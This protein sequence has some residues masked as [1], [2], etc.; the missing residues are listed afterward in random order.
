MA[1]LVSQWLIDIPPIESETRLLMMK[2]VQCPF[3]PN[4]VPR[5]IYQLHVEECHCETYRP[6]LLN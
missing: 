5:T 1:E 6:S 3:C 2:L 4:K